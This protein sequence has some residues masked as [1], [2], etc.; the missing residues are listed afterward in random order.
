[1]EDIETNIDKLRRIRAMG[2]G[3]AIDDFGTGYSSLGYLAKLPA[4][5][6]KIDRSFIARMLDDDDAMALVQTILSLANSLK[7]TTVAEGVESEE[8]A[9]MLEL[10]GCNEIQGYFISK[11]KP[12]QDITSILMRNPRDAAPAPSQPR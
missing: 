10:L 12:R 1:M 5:I 9:D 2:I 11:P 6:L 4:N 7:L 3:V 8:Q